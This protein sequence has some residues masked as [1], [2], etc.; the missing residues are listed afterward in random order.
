MAVKLFFMASLA[1]KLQNGLSHFCSFVKLEY[2]VNT[3]KL[4]MV[5]IYS[6]KSLWLIEKLPQ[7]AK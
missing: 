2:K 7:S 3:M 6:I 5:A 4:L 1:L